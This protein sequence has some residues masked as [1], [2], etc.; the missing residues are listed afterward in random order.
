MALE[1][2]EY[3][4]GSFSAELVEDDHL[5]NS[6]NLTEDDHDNTPI[7]PNSLMV[8]VE[9]IHA[10]PH[11]T[12]N[13]T[14]YM[15][16]CLKNSVP[17]WTHPYNRPLIKHHNEK[18]GKIIG[19]ILNAEYKTKGTFSNTP[20]LLFTVN[21][22]GEDAKED[23]LNGTEST[24]SIGVIAHD[25]RC[26]ICGQ[27]LAG[28]ESCGHERGV[29]YDGETCY[30]DIYSMEAKGL[31]YV[32]VPSDIYAKN[33]KIYPATE[34]KSGDKT[35][36]TE[37]LDETIK[38]G[39]QQMAEDNQKE[40]TEAKATIS[41]LEAKVSELTEAK[42]ASE[43]KVAELTE[44]NQALEAQ[45]TELTEAKATLEEQAKQETALKE[46]L[47]S[48]LEEA[49]VA[50]KDS[51]I[52]AMQALRK[53]AGKHELSV[54]DVKNRCEESISDA[55]FD[56]KEELSEKAAATPVA[57]TLAPGSVQDP[58]LSEG[59]GEAKGTKEVK[60]SNEFDHIDLQAGLS[61]LFQSVVSYHK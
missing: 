6:I 5:L 10:F 53:A 35:Q 57:E 31:S 12:R 19:R 50:R 36:I 45:V 2:Q 24:V 55:I 28:G 13:F 44:A 37:S 56:L 47:E 60:E 41:D 1:I 3:V 4:G 58:S 22:P 51:L 30:W 21:V 61:N 23:I 26:S 34:T 18:N 7:A 33:R 16:K 54:D 20:A 46:G 8:D 14:R 29:E 43:K 11:A 39:E 17:T 9:G 32:V 40:L 38:K 59:E 27:Q 52:E 48:A 25:V 42:T 15:P 49:K